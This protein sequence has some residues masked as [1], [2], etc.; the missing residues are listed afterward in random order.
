MIDDWHFCPR[1]ATDLQHVRHQSNP[2]VHCP[3]CGFSKWN[4]PLPSTVAIIA[5]DSKV[6]LLERAQEPHRGEWDSV[7]GFIQPGESA[8]ECVRREAREEIGQNV[9]ITTCLG[10]FPSIYGTT[11][12]VTLGIA[13]TCELTQAD[14]TISD[15]NSAYGWFDI[16]SLPTIALRDVRD[17]FAQFQSSVGEVRR[18]SVHP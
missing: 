3:N 5:R 14:I 8:E 2:Y 9:L 6:L 17:A 1:C 10:T 13:F 11:G 16:E 12:L 18:S 4:N 7:G 15:E